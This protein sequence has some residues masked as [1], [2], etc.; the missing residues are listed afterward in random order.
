MK[1]PA[2]Q[3]GFDRFIKLEWAEAALRVRAGVSNLDDLAKVLD[4]SHHGTAAK[5]KTRTVLNRLWLEPLRSDLVE[6]ADRGAKIYRDGPDISVP[7]MTWGMALA[8]YPFFGK[9][10]EIVGRL[11]ALQ[12]E[13]TSAEIHR[14]M[15]E[16]Y[17][18]REGTRRMT[19]MVLQSQASWG[20]IER[21]ENGKRIVRKKSIDL[22]G[23]PVAAWLAEACLR[24][25]GR[26]L[27]VASLDSNPMIYP[28]ALGGSISYRLSKSSTVEMR[29]DGTGNQV[30]GLSS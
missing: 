30:I 28:F 6:F 2:P 21:L 12:G 26:S 1:L 3:I 23:S 10:A 18:E 19:N 9:V 20:A 14:R 8:T 24:Y 13:C 16:I 27:P 22:H 29:V 25:A 7:A 4:A 11:T 17:G 15:A 5:K